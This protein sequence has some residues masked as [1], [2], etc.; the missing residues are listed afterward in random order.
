[1]LDNIS[2]PMQG[3]ENGDIYFAFVSIMF[4]LEYP[5]IW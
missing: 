2:V 4:F 1:M 5:F 3:L